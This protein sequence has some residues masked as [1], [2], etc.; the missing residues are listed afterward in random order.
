MNA[1]V[2]RTRDLV[3]GIV[4]RISEL[5]IRSLETHQKVLVELWWKNFP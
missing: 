1:Q 3:S 4:D 5:G 2:K